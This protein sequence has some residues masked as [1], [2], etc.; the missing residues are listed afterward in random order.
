MEYW[1]QISDVTL[2][3]SQP[4][5][6]ILMLLLVAVLLPPANKFVADKFNFSISGGLKVIIV[7]GLLIVIGMSMS[8]DSPTKNTV[9]SNNNTSQNQ[10]SETNTEKKSILETENDNNAPA[11]QNQPTQTQSELEPDTPSETISQKNAVRK[12]K[13]YL[14]YTTFSR[15]GLVEQLKFDQFSHADAVYGADNSGADWYEQAAKKAQSY[16]EYSAFSRGSL[17]EQLKFDGFT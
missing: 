11:T 9:T 13:S 8:T 5:T 14:N 7:I 12:A 10:E 3:F 16:M 1:R 6:G 17:I 2:L 15:D 4:L